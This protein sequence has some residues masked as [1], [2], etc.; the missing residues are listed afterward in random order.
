M[1]HRNTAYWPERYTPLSLLEKAAA[2]RQRA[3]K[4]LDAAAKTASLKHLEQ[5]ARRAQARAAES[6]SPDNLNAAGSIA[7][8]A[9]GSAA[10]LAEKL[11]AIDQGNCPE[12]PAF[13]IVYREPDIAGVPENWI[14]EVYTV[15][16]HERAPCLRTW[17]GTQPETCRTKAQAIAD[18]RDLASHPE[19]QRQARGTDYHAARVRAACRCALETAPTEVRI[20]LAGDERPENWEKPR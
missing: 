8:L 13:A 1:A 9:A 20:R 7:N 5:N 16:G 11:A 10:R 19:M 3:A 18:L 12:P 17:S 15:C 4:Y 2:W 6:P 14:A